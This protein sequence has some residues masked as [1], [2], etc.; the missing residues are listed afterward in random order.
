MNMLAVSW[1]EWGLAWILILVCCFLM[2]V[3]LL[4]RGRGGGLSAAFGGGGGSSAA[5]G[6]KTGDV[7]TWITV[8]GATLFVLLA[9]IA[10]YA[11]DKSV[12]TA[13]PR[14]ATGTTAPAQPAAPVGEGEAEMPTAPATEEGGAETAGPFGIEE[15]SGDAE[16][17]TQDEPAFAP[18]DA[19]ARGEDEPAAVPDVP[20]GQDGAGGAT[21]SSD[22]GAEDQPDP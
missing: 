6:A 3:I 12:P 14:S 5:F 9:V 21:E 4:Q 15:P 20:G 8:A 18:E 19:A 16:A 17:G 10:N 11:F 13:P 2:L 1:L 7:F 22:H